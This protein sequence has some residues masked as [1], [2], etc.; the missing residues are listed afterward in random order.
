MAPDYKSLEKKIMEK[1][2]KEGKGGKRRER[3]ERKTSR[4]KALN[5]QQ[6]PYSLYLYTFFS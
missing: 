2:E 6:S 5:G 1:E 4:P 3:G